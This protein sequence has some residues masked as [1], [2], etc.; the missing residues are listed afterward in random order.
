MPRMLGFDEHFAGEW[1]RGG[2]KRGLHMHSRWP[3]CKCA[4]CYSLL[5]TEMLAPRPLTH[6]PRLPARLPA[7]HPSLVVTAA[8]SSAGE[9]DRP[10]F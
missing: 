7:G 2:V 6:H 4:R 9:G 10:P 8:D 5:G 3:S 1:E